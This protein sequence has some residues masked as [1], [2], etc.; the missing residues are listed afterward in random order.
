VNLPFGTF[1]DRL[2][3][4][5]RTEFFAWFSLEEVER[6]ED[7]R[8]AT[9]VRFKPEGASFRELV[10]VEAETASGDELR[11]LRLFIARSFIADERN[12]PFADDI[13]ASFLQSG[14]P[15]DDAETIAPLAAQ[16]R[17]VHAASVIVRAGPAPR[18][19]TPPGD[20]FLT[21]VGQRHAFEQRLS[22][23]MITMENVVDGADSML[24][25]RLSKLA[26]P[27]R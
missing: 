15:P 9:I 6:F 19:P 1:G 26:P 23:T 16:I 24:Q 10:T 21:Y 12:G 11:S 3:T 8:G 13:A 5:T 17:N 20:G 7:D 22:R 25:L 2:S 18:V 4:A 14:T 27:G